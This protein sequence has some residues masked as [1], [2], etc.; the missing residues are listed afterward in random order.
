MCIGMEM[1]VVVDRI[2]PKASPAVLPKCLAKPLCLISCLRGKDTSEK[3]RRKVAVGDI[4]SLFEVNLPRPFHAACTPW[5]D[6]VPTVDVAPG[7]P[8]LMYV[9]PPALWLLFFT[10]A[11]TGAGTTR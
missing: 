2:G 6:W 5:D 10:F 9:A 8:E 4:A 7:V 3:Q 1:C 11:L